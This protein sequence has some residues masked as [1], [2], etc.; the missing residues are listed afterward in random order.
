LNRS[1]SV[2]LQGYSKAGTGGDRPPQGA[3]SSLTGAYVEELASAPARRTRNLL[4]IHLEAL[5][6]ESD[7]P[8]TS[9]PNSRDPMVNAY[10]RMLERTGE[11]FE[12]AERETAPRLRQAIERVR[13]NMVE[14]GELTREEAARVADYVERDIRDAA[15]Y[16][17]DTGDTLRKWWRFDLNLVEQRLLD[18]FGLVADRTSVQLQSWAEQ[19]RQASLYHSGEIAG[20][21]A[22]YCT[23]CGAELK[24]Q[25]A[26]RIPPC[27]ACQGTRFS[28]TAAAGEKA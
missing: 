15:A 20:P 23:A 22:L 16:I 7:K 3:G 24:M 26:G 2:G 13:D 19:A 28:R 8:N 10:E 11:M 9:D 25:K 4:P 17:A 1:K 5:M 21:G 6:N 18:L 27:P 12:R 14:F